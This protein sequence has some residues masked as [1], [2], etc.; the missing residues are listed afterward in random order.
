MEDKDKYKVISLLEAGQDP[1]DVADDVG[2][3]YSSVIRLRSQL[4]EAKTNG[5]IAS[6]IDTDRLLI[7]QVGEELQLQEEVTKITKGLDGLETLNSELQK[8]ALAL[9]QQTKSSLLSA[10]H[11][12]ELQVFC[13]II[14]DLQ[15]AFFNKNQTQINV[16]NNIGDSGAPKYTKFLSDKPG[17]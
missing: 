14:C 11:A 13:G 17:A 6:L 7:E 3:S 16:Q 1:R 5:T 4:K 10:E 15:N 12:S 9:V 8:T 2:V